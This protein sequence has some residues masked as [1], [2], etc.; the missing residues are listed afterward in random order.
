MNLEETGW[1]FSQNVSQM[2]V[3]FSWKILSWITQPYCYNATF[4]PNNLH[5][6]CAENDGV[7]FRES[8][9]GR[10]V[11]GRGSGVRLGTQCGK[12]ACGESFSL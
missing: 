10:V 3:L 4:S 1:P 2:Q 8:V 6:D 11:K 9:G 12:P 7:C 5:C